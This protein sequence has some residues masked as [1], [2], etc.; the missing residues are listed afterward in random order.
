MLQ[1]T[2]SLIALGVKGIGW[3][4][5][6]TQDFIFLTCLSLTFS[7]SVSV[8]LSLLFPSKSWPG[9]PKYAG[10]KERWPDPG[11]VQVHSLIWGHK[12]RKRREAGN[13]GI[14]LPT[15]AYHA[16]TRRQK[17][18][19]EAKAYQGSVTLTTSVLLVRSLIS[20][21]SMFTSLPEVLG[22]E[23]TE[24]P[25][26]SR[27]GKNFWSAGVPASIIIMTILTMY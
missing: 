27:V 13:Q 19:K 11:E 8:F 4:T 12:I 25:K 1:S 7:V 9:I 5:G 17:C 16:E 18:K 6:L 23:R 14:G 15:S 21:V 10:R 3:V 22:R 20:Q 2:T 26:L 24:R